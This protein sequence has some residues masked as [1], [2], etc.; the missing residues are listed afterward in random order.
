MYAITFPEYILSGCDH[1]TYIYTYM[2]VF[3]QF[4]LNITL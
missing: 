2:Y 3:I 1:N 4:F